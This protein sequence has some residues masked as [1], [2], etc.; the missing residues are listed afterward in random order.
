[1]ARYDDQITRLQAENRHDEVV[2]KDCE[3]AS[4][5]IAALFSGLAEDETHEQARLFR[6]MIAHRKEMITFYEQLNAKERA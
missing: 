2:L 1:M 3:K 4:G 5:G 6:R